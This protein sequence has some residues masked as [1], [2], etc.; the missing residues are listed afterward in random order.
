MLNDVNNG[1][2]DVFQSGDIL[3]EVETDKAQIEVEAPE[4]GR[5][6][7]WLSSPGSASVAVNTPIAYYSDD[8]DGSED[9]PGI[10]D[11]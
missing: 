10:I 3:F 6:L 4:E 2:G 1:L 9:V 7:Q 8:V 11:L 5:F